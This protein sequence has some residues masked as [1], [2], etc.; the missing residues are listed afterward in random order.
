MME[1]AACIKQ[2][3]NSNKML[4]GKPEGRHRLADLGMKTV[5]GEMDV[6][7]MGRLL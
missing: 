1:C 7:A 3:R 6:G 2:K 4:D 5:L